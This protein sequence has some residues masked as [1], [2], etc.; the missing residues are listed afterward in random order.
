M[1]KTL[2]LTMV[3]ASLAWLSG[4]ATSKSLDGFNRGSSGG[5]GGGS[6]AFQAGNWSFHATG[7]INGD[8]YM[9]GY[10][11]GSS[12]TFGGKMQVFG[13]AAT[14]FTLAKGATPM[15]LTGSVTNGTLTMTGNLGSSAF[16]FTFPNI[17]SGVTTT[18]LDGT[19]TVVG[20]ADTGDSGSVGGLIVPDGAYT[21]TWAGSSS[22]SG[23]TTTFNFTEGS[24]PSTD[25]TFPLTATTA[26]GVAFSA[27]SG[28][29]VTGNLV[30]Q[31]SYAAGPLVVLDATTVDNGVAG[32]VRFIGITNNY[33]SPTQLTGNGY[34]YNGGSA[35]FLD[36][37]GTL[38]SYALTKQ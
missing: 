8:I 37:S 15:T 3:V 5:S 9:G 29:V 12:G 10:L 18:S 4:C 28:C 19:Y 21:G 14:G 32:E 13:Q 27:L 2:L 35:C 6:A 20:G 17:A 23:G 36:N 11:S 1:K 33:V 24:T 34:V 26:P 22:V 31:Y 7:G 25:G 38:I 30:P 16:T